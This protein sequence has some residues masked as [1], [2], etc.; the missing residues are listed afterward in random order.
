M[1]PGQWMATKSVIMWQHRGVESLFFFF[2]FTLKFWE[3]N[4]WSAILNQ[5]HKTSSWL[6]FAFVLVIQIHS[7]DSWL[8]SHEFYGSFSPKLVFQQSCAKLLSRQMHHLETFPELGNRTY[9]TRG[10]IIWCH[11]SS[12]LLPKSVYNI[13]ARA[14]CLLPNNWKSIAGH[15]AEPKKYS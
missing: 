8:V 14:A 1:G 4:R 9:R 3:R 5:L 2:W 11:Y 12:K 15:K 7:R 10:S 13:W 6:R